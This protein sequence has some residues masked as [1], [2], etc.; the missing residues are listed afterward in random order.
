MEPLA[1]FSLDLIEERI[2][3][4]AVSTSSTKASKEEYDPSCIRLAIVVGSSRWASL[5]RLA[6]GSPAGD[7]FVEVLIG[8][9]RMEGWVSWLR[10]S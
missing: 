9:L 8:R 5:V 1:R 4:L 7:R 10:S 3:V 2:S 6:D